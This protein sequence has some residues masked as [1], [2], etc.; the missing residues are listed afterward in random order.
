MNLFSPNAGL[1]NRFVRDETGALEPVA[2]LAIVT[3]LIITA[4]I[5]LAGRLGRGSASVPRR[6]T[7]LESAQ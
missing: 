2:A 4:A 7:G 3:M 5:A 1:V 6:G